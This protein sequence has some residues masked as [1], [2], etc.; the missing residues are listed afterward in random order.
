MDKHN[1]WSIRL[2]FSGKQSPLIA[3]MGLEQF[4]EASYGSKFSQEI[5]DFLKDSPKTLQA[6]RAKRQALQNSSAE[7]TKEMLKKE[8]QVSFEMKSWWI[9]KMR[10]EEFPLREKMTCFWHNHF[11]STYQKVKVNH[12]IFQHNQLLREQAFGNFKTL[13]KLVLQTNAMVRYLDNVDNRRDKINENLSRELLELFTLGIGNY[14]E[15]DIKN[16]A[17]GLAGLNL[18]EDQAVY[19]KLL[20]NNDTITYFGKTGKFKAEEMVDIIFEQQA[21]PYLL[22]RKILQ[23]F[24]YDNPPEAL[25]A[26]YGEY[27][28]K[29]DF[30]IK[31]L[32]IKIFT[33]EYPK[34]TAGSKIKD[35]LVY[36]LQLMHELN[37]LGMNPKL[38]A[39]FLKQ[40]GMDLF[41]QPNVK[42]WN[43]GKEWLTS[44]IYLQR[45]NVADLLC[46]GRSWNRRIQFTN[47]MITENMPQLNVKVNWDTNGNHKSI[48]ADLAN[49]LLF[50]NDETLQK[51]WESIL[52]YDFN[53]KAENADNAVLRLFNAMI[54]TPEFQII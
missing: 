50:K 17:K 2:G 10:S 25:V 21:A 12:W 23:W 42:G 1:L 22:T 8:L 34:D 45:N 13:T 43:G 16:G 47:E 33:E 54:K 32:L 19:R 4:L 52:K 39:F 28:R 9:E 11:V 35:P 46:D 29:V 26:Y 41:N 14:T 30:E 37:A 31:P 49:R 38:V 53:P 24:I 48:I 3:T 15:E 7:E 20:E 6:L 36:I 40:Q 5:P 44:Q 51:E 18:G 27:F